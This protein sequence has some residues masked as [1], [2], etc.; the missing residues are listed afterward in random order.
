MAG[1]RIIVAV[2]AAKERNVKLLIEL[3][4]HVENVEESARAVVGNGLQ[5]VFDAVN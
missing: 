2:A 5:F 1:F 4:R 3:N